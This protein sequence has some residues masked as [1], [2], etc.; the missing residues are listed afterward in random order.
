MRRGVRLAGVLGLVA[1]AGVVVAL[2][3]FPVDRYRPTA[4]AR[5]SEWLQAPVTLGRL[6]PALFGDFGVRSEGFRMGPFRGPDA[7]ARVTLS[8]RTA[9]VR[10]AFWPLLR[11]DV[12]LQGLELRDATLMR[13]ER[14]L[15]SGRVR[16][17]LARTAEGRL[18]FVGDVDGRLEAL[19][20]TPRCAGEFDATLVEDRLELGRIDARLAAGS[21]TG[22]GALEGLRSRALRCALDG[23]FAFGASRGAGQAAVAWNGGAAEAVFDLAFEEA[24]L[25]D[26]APIAAALAGRPAPAPGA[27]ADGGTARPASLRLAGEIRAARLALGRLAFEDTSATV[28]FS[29]G[30]LRVPQLRARAYGGSV[31]SSGSAALLLPGA[32]F[33]CT[34][35]IEGIDAGRLSE[36]LADEGWPVV[37]GTVVLD[38]SVRGS[39]AQGRPDAGT[40]AGSVTLAVR[41]GR[42]KHLALLAQLTTLVNHSGRGEVRRD[43]TPFRSITAS[44][45]VADG[46][47]RTDDLRLRSDEIDLDGKGSL[48][49]RGEIDLHLTAS[50]APA[51]TSALETRVPGLRPWSE[52]GRLAIPV[53]LAGSLDE[54][55][56]RIDIDRAASRGLARFF[57]E[58]GKKGVLRRLLG[59]R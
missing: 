24:R 38:A 54:P 27:A 43:D 5:L 55:R 14:R 57:G 32:P 25:D 39:M 59:G 40:L 19:P 1:A 6:S 3:G 16:T 28:A 49:L 11:G 58:A 2:Y 42:M 18:R 30:T 31:A 29:D 36:A 17:T 20:G 10:L 23:R 33:E 50:L 8:A 7:L 53:D 35:R 37:E 41:D 44:F 51:V 21:F 34:S 46:T 48:T 26:L 52:G 13:G 4:E 56:V 15:A 12:R 22:A 9:H 47:A 45:A